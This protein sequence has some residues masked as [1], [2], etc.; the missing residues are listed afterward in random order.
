M[1]K[2]NRVHSTPRRT[3]SKIKAKK[4]AKPASAES[5][6]QRDQRHG[7]D[8]RDLESPVRELFCMSEITH[9]LA[10][11]LSPGHRSEILHFSIS[12]LYAMIRDFS[13][14]YR[15]DIHAKPA[16]GKAVV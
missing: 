14:K 13:A 11:E 15:A 7:E 12:R 4:S 5:Q 2:A 10:M 3:A 6:E 1:P 16:R 8:F 9:D